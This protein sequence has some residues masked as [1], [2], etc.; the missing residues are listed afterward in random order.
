MYLLTGHCFLPIW[1]LAED[2][3]LDDTLLLVMYILLLFF[4]LPSMALPILLP[5]SAAKLLL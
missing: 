4:A 3:L 1:L 2:E 5:C